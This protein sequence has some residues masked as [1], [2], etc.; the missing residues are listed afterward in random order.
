MVS[1]ADDLLQI[2]LPSL[3]K[4]LR[5]CGFTVKRRAGSVFVDLT[6][7]NDTLLYMARDLTFK[8]ICAW[9]AYMQL[10]LHSHHWHWVPKKITMLKKWCTLANNIKNSPIQHLH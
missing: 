1:D 5:I 10:Q 9:S 3:P 6:A 4:K 2:K 8:T 7:A